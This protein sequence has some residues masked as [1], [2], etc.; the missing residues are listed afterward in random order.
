MGQPQ[1]K[2]CVPAVCS[3]NKQIHETVSL[4]NSLCRMHR[5]EAYV[6][7][8][9]FKQKDARVASAELDGSLF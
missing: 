2:L 5:V 3:S 1:V 7:V 4:I 9:I 6:L 8:I